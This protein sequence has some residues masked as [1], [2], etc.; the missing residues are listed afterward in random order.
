MPISAENRKLYPKN[1][2]VIRAEIRA[3]AK[4]ACEMCGVAN[5]SMEPRG[6]PEEEMGAVRMVRIVCTVAH[7]NHNPRDNRRANLAFLCQKCHNRHDSKH[8]QANAARTRDLKRG[9]SRLF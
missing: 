8:R 2:Q 1:W 3:R 4:D 6:E 9:Q 5:H 7:L